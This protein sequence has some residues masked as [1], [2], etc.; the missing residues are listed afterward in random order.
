M[1]L[2]HREGLLKLINDGIKEIPATYSK[3]AP[4]TVTSKQA[5]EEI[6]T[7]GGLGLFQNFNEAEGVAYDA[8]VPRFSKR[9]T[10]ILRSLG[11]KYTKQSQQKDLY[12]FIKSIAP[13]MADSAV[14]TLNLLACN[15]LNFGF[16]STLMAAPDGQALFSSSHP[17]AQGTS[18]TDSNYVTDTLSGLALENAIQQVRQ[19]KGDRGI[20]KYFRGGFNLV[21]GPLNEG[22]AIRSVRSFGLQGTSDNDTNSFVNSSIKE[23][24]VDQFIGYNMSGASYRWFLI[25]SDAKDNPIFQ[26]QVQGI[27]TDMDK[28]ID[29]QSIKMVATFETLFDVLGW[30]GTLGSYV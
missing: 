26:L 27:E 7:H 22:I 1:P 3:I 19:V 8:I 2:I 21:V 4:T 10:P 23:I 9:Y 6:Q 24:V 17:I 30:R 5:F 12:G 28:D 14:A 25:P 13:M 20:P 16:S 15:V 18:T 11:V 29:G